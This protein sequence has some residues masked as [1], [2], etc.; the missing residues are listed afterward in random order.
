MNSISLDCWNWLAC[1]S[2]FQSVGTYAYT[3]WKSWLATRSSQFAIR[4]SQLWK[5]L[6]NQFV[7]S[8]PWA[9]TPRRPRDN[10][11]L[12]APNRVLIE[13][14]SQT[15]FTACYDWWQSI[16][17]LWGCPQGCSF[18]FCL[19]Y[20]LSHRWPLTGVKIQPRSFKI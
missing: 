4:N 15:Q 10:G 8:T 2:V 6:L 11:T 7:F 20:L 5:R 9:K 16:E 14:L 13:W 1:L 18:C 17:S 12:E 3:L 19:C